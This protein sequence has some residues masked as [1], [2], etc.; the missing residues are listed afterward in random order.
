M[1]F[2]DS[3]AMHQHQEHVMWDVANGQ[4]SAVPML[5]TKVEVKWPMTISA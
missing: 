1:Q 5:F 2:Q 4:I 3:K